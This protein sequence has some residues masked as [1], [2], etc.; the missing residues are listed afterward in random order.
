MC[1]DA[2]MKETTT[3]KGKTMTD[4]GMTHTYRLPKRF[5]EDHV[6]RGCRCHE[7]CPDRDAHE[8]E[9]M[10]STSRHYVVDLTPMDVAEL[11]SDA[12]HYATGMDWLPREFIGLVSSAR[13]TLKA[14]ER[15]EAG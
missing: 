15:G 2:G 13:A 11:V 8:A 7:R 12:E 6:D 1:N 10:V 9:P 5:W 4:N 14:V 3:Q